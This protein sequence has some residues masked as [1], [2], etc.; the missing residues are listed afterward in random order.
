[1]GAWDLMTA[2]EEEFAAKAVYDDAARASRVIVLHNPYGDIRLDKRVFSGPWDEQ[3]DVSEDGA[4][5]LVVP[6]ERTWELPD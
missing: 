2:T 5:T 1:M 3:F 6:A 4:Y